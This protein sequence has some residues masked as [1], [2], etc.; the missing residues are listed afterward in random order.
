MAKLQRKKEKQPQVPELPEA[1]YRCY[2]PV[3]NSNNNTKIRVVKEPDLQMTSVFEDNKLVDRGW[4]CQKCIEALRNG[5]G[6][7]ERLVIANV[8]VELSLAWRKRLY[9]GEDVDTYVRR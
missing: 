1:F 9:L 8:S 3:C 4:Y 5:E 7:K 6:E 2:G